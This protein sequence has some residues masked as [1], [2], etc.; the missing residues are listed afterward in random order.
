MVGGPTASADR[1]HI[2]LLKSNGSVVTRENADGGFLSTGRQGLFSTRVDPGDSIV[3]P[4]KL[5]ETRLMKD[6]KDITQ[7]LYQIAVMSG[8][9]ILAF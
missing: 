8:I 7:I 9:V 1:D 5:L 2:F 4:E 3:V 6:V